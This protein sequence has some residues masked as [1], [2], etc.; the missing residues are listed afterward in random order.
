VINAGP[1]M[2]FLNGGTGS[3]TFYL[4]GPNQGLDT[5]TGFSPT[6]HDVLN[7]SRT[8]AAATTAVD[9]TNVG[10]FITA[11]AS[12]GNTTLYVDETGGHGTPV[13]FAVLDGVTTTVAQLVAN[14]DLKL[15]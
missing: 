3:D 8:L 11:V 4:N 12:G 6:I 7:L 2:N 15:S 14:N 13:A 5:I 10:N 9:L 1:G